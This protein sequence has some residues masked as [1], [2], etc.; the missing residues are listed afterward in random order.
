M[1]TYRDRDVL[2]RL[3]VYPGMDAAESRVLRQFIKRRGAEFVEWRFMVR[4]GEGSD[5]GAVV[6]E[7]TRKAWRALTKAR[8][9]V[10]AM[11]SPTDATI[12]EAKDRWANDAVW[13]L[14]G[15][16][17]LYA[18]T[19]PDHRVSLVGVAREAT[20]TAKALASARRIPLYVYALPPALPDIDETASE[21]GPHA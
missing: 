14:L 16:R 17:D 21:E 8:T 6:D 3:P 15:Y 20:E 18:A 13:Q 2:A 5:A 4:I 9:D 12:I 1:I 19:F 11:R 10:V 7:S